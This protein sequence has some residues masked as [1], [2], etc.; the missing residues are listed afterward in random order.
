MT[1]LQRSSKGYDAIWIIVD[2]LTKLAH[3]LAYRTG[4]TLDQLA[5]LYIDEIMRLHGISKSIVS[6][7]D[8]RLTSHF[9]K[10]FQKALGS[11]LEFS[12]TFYL[13]IDG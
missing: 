11:I 8:S 6:D 9:W 5:Q 12:T 13:Q 4:M 7:I 1:G 10:S 2:R 3:F